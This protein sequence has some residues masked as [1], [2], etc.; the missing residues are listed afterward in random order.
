MKLAAQSVMVSKF[1]LNLTLKNLLQHSIPQIKS[2]Q[3]PVKKTPPSP[4][5]PRPNNVE[6][7]PENTL[8]GIYL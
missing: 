2:W 1:S 6:R 7:I 5:P 3:G 4:P 8:R